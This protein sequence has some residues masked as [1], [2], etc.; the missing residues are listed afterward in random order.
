MEV[1]IFRILSKLNF[2]R[3]LNS[4]RVVDDTLCWPSPPTIHEYLHAHHVEGCTLYA[5]SL[6]L[7]IYTTSTPS[8]EA[9]MIASTNITSLNVE[10][11]SLVRVCTA[12]CSSRSQ[13]HHT[14]PIKGR[15]ELGSVVCLVGVRI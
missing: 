12:L 7:A 15:L 2:A 14:R 11:C 4:T 10:L 8:T 9:G 13:I 5:T 6:A 3:A 1:W